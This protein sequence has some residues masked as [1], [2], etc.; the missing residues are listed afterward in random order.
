MVRLNVSDAKEELRKAALHYAREG[1]RREEDLLAAALRFAAAKRRRN[2]SRDAW[3]MK[4]RLGE[5]S[6]G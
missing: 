1:Y 5:G 2:N 3:K 6:N 4:H